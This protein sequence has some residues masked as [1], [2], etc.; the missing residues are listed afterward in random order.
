MSEVKSSFLFFCLLWKEETV[1]LDVLMTIR[2]S[3]EG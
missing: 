1:M 3:E 2:L